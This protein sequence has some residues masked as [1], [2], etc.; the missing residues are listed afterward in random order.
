MFR[1]LYA[2]Y[3]RISVLIGFFF[4]GNNYF[5]NGIYQGNGK[6]FFF[7]GLNCYACPLARFSCPLG[8]LQHFIGIKT[9]PFY[10]LGFLGLIGISLGRLVCGWV[11]PFGFFQELLYKIKTYKIQVSQK[12]SYSK[13]LVLFILVVFLPVLTNQPWFCRLCPA[14]GIEAGIPQIISN[15]SLR[16][17]IGILFYIKIGIVLVLI[18]SSIF[19]K[20][21]FCRFTCPLGAIYGIFNKITLFRIRVDESKCTKCY[22][23]QEVCPMDIKIFEVPDAVDCIKCGECIRN[24]P[25]GVLSFKYGFSPDFKGSFEKDKNSSS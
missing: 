25:E 10:V 2:K 8:T 14:G 16:P 22:T 4:A 21:P 5:I 7:P 24:C 9:F 20:R 11:C 19:I 17:L 13:Y 23:C 6:G 3:V 18:S 1:W 15:A 12:Y